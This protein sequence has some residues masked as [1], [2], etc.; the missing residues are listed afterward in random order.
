MRKRYRDMQ[1]WEQDEYVKNILGGI[2]VGILW[3]TIFIMLA[4]RLAE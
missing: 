3:V 1:P 4:I 2:L